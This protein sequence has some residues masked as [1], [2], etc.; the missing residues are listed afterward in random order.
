[1]VEPSMIES[2]TTSLEF[3]CLS[4]GM[5][6]I[7]SGLQLLSLATV[8]ATHVEQYDA[9]HLR[10]W[11]PR[12][13]FIVRHVP[14]QPKEATHL[15]ASTCPQSVSRTRASCKT[16]VELA[17]MFSIPADYSRSSEFLAMLRV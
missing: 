9:G 1:M 13:Q 2:G 12:V 5:E 8:A 6:G 10:R 17:S 7:T 3:G 11:L 14:M 15:N 16:V 4:S